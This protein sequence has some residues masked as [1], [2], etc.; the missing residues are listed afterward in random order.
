MRGPQIERSGQ[1]TCA[2]RQ[3]AQAGQPVHTNTGQQHEADLADLQQGFT[4]GQVEQ[5]L[6]RVV[7]NVSV[8]A[9]IDNELAPV[10][11]V[12]QLL[13]LCDPRD[14]A[15]A[16]EEHGWVAGVEYQQEAV[17]RRK[18]GEQPVQPRV[19]SLVIPGGCRDRVAAAYVY[20]FA[21]QVPH[22][23]R[24]RSDTGK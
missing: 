18:A 14:G 10:A 7:A 5:R 4:A 22:Y 8:G 1:T 9:E 24:L 16:A 3:L 12:P 21:S 23:R 6:W 20:R 15:I 2:S 13:N 17:Q 19:A 11:Q